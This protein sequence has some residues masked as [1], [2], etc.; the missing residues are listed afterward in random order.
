MLPILYG[1][2]HKKVAGRFGFPVED[3]SAGNTP[4]KK[5]IS[6]TQKETRSAFEKDFFKLNIAQSDNNCQTLDSNTGVEINS[7]ML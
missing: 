3:T 6:D 4:S 1:P 2:F 7:G 5:N